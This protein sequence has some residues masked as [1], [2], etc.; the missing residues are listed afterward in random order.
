MM[1]LFPPL[2]RPFV[3]CLQSVTHAGAAAYVHAGRPA[4]RPVAFRVRRVR[5]AYHAEAVDGTP[6]G[7]IDAPLALGSVLK[8][9][10]LSGWQV[11]RERGGWRVTI[12][13]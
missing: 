11:R 3:T 5:L 1:P 7:L 10:V 9:C 8:L 4:G 13:A 6:I 12:G 2:S